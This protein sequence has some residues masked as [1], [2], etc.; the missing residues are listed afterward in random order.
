M[1]QTENTQKSGLRSIAFLHASAVSSESSHWSEKVHLLPSLPLFLALTNM[2]A[3]PPRENHLRH[4][5]KIEWRELLFFR[6]WQGN[7][8]V[9][10]AYFLSVA[11]A[12]VVLI[13]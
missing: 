3:F 2:D 10:L 12:L 8:A 5:H 13:K 9:R 6:S 4:R 1:S 11:L 7:G